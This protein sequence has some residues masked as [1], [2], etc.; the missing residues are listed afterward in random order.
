MENFLFVLLLILLI[1]A[2][3]TMYVRY[4]LNEKVVW[5]TRI[6][7]WRLY[8]SELIFY[9]PAFLFFMFFLIKG[10][11]HR[12]KTA[13]GAWLITILW[14]VGISQMIHGLMRGAPGNYWLADFRQTVAM[15]YVAFCICILAT[16]IRLWKVLDRFCKVGAVFAVYNGVMGALTFAGLLSRESL[17][18]PFFVAEVIFILMYAFVLGRSLVTNKGSKIILWML[19]FGIVTPLHKPTVAIFVTTNIAIFFIFSRTGKAISMD[20]F[21]KYIKMFLIIGISLSILLGWVFTLGEGSAKE[22]INR[23]YLKAHVT[24]G[25]DISGRRFFLYQWGFEQWKKH[26]LFGTG[27]GHHLFEIDAKGEPKLTGVHNYFLLYLYQTGTVCFLTVSAVFICW[28]S[29]IYRYLKVCYS[30]E[31][32]WPLAS[33]FSWILAM[34]LNSLVGTSLGL[35][36]IGF[37]FWISVGFLTNAEAQY[38][39]SEQMGD[40]SYS[41]ESGYLLT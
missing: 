40:I 14:V 20:L 26:P 35:T 38:H 31:E 6:T 41:D 11:V 23:R 10:N 19:I 13:R 30:P 8:P 18:T 22:W 12:Y 1:E 28:L 21:Y 17:F 3:F 15:S 33:M 16:R 4:T 37:I 34:L 39:I 32:Y 29:R 24:G 36:T 2:V 5:W 27:F 25:G 9:G 7:P